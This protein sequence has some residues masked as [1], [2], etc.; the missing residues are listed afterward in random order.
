MFEYPS[1]QAIWQK[2]R[3]VLLQ[4]FVAQIGFVHDV[5]PEGTIPSDIQQTRENLNTRRVMRRSREE[6]WLGLAWGL[7]KYQTIERSVRSMRR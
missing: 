2:W 7:Y 6:L 3:K 5:G 4:L 1:D